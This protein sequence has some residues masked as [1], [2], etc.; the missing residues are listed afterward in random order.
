MRAV[1]PKPAQVADTTVLI[2]SDHQIYRSGLRILLDGVDTFHVV[3]ESGTG[4]DVVAMAHSLRPQ[5]VVM[6]I[7]RPGESVADV[8]SPI[9]GC[10][11]DTAVLIISP[12][13]DRE[14]FLSTMRAG[15]R[16]YL[17]NGACW[18][19]LVRAVGM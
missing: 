9:A 13:D 7:V 6:D 11:P 18:Q 17:R 8:I 10:C 4:P 3:G 2:A 16:A 1:A 15:A 5:V 14:T 12:L 19:D